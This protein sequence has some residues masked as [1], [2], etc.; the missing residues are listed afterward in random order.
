MV[1]S[2]V[3]PK[4]QPIS[5]HNLSPH[6]VTPRIGSFETLNEDKFWED[7]D[8]DSLKEEQ[9]KIETTLNFLLNYNCTKKKVG[10]P[11]KSESGKNPNKQTLQIPDTV[12]DE[13][14]SFTDINVLH[15]GVLLDY[16]KKIN[17]FNKKILNTLDSIKTKYDE[18]VNK[19]DC[20]HVTKPT[21]PPSNITPTSPT[22][23]SP[24]NEA[25]STD[26]NLN[27]ELKL[28]VDSL[29]QKSFSNIIL[30]CGSEVSS[31]LSRQNI[32]YENEIKNKLRDININCD[33]NEINKVSP[34]GKSRKYVKIY[35]S[36]A[37]VKNR[38]LYEIRKRKPSNFYCSEFL[39]SYRDNIYFQLRSLKKKYPSKIS[40]VYTRG[41]QIFYKLVPGGDYKCIQRLNEVVQLEQQLLSNVN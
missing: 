3:T 27:D 21:V 6:T 17:C 13:L 33:D 35:C 41:G 26:K 37:T 16:L 40:A 9:S 39:T 8:V 28:K 15:P 2:P 34:F 19:K 18:L 10:R 25:V 24:L 7:I 20:E 11:A 5:N 12:S 14:K 23:S 29:E 31:L 38:I 36:T 1:T 22:S 32:N 4:T 30:C